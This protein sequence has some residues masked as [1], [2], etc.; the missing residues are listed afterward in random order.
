[1]AGVAQNHPFEPGNKRTAFGAMRL[2]L[3]ANGFDTA[4]D[5]T[6]DWADQIIELVEHRLTEEE[7]VSALRPYVVPRGGGG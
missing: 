7:F 2:F 4:F 3:R 5:D 6:V 1:M